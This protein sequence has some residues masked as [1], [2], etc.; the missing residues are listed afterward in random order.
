MKILF[1]RSGNKGTDPISTRQAVSIE[2]LGHKVIF[3]DIVGKGLLGYLRNVFSLKKMIAA[4]KPDI[5]HAHYSLSGFVVS[6][7]GTNIRIVT[8]IMGSDVLSCKKTIFK[9]VRYSALKRWSHTIVKSKQ[10]SDK[11]M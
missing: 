10:I 8:S 7:T 1:V 9:L 4:Q 2:K 11:L 5:I 6:L 3:Y